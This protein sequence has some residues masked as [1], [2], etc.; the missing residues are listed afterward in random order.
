MKNETSKIWDNKAL[1]VLISII[2]AIL[3][4]VYVTTTEGDVREKTFEGV[5]VVLNGVDGLRD[6][7]NF[8]I[9]DVSANSVTVTLRGTLRNLSKLTANNIK[10]VVDV[11]KITSKGNNTMPFTMEYPVGIDKGSLDLVSSLPET[12]S[13]YVDKASSKSVEL[14]GDFSKGSVSEGFVAGTV[15]FDPREVTISG[16]ENEIN[17]VSYAFVEITRENVDKTLKFDSEYTLVDAEGKEVELGNIRL[18]PQTVSVTL[19]ITAT[20]E[21][22]LSV[23]IVDGGGATMENVKLKFE[24]E[25][26]TIAGDAA[27]LEGI[28]KISLG[29][30]DLSSFVSTF[31]EKFPIVLD[32]EVSN[33]TGLTEAK[34]TVEVLGLKTAMFNVTN[35]SI[36]NTPAGRI[37]SPVTEMVEVMLRGSQDAIDK[38]KANNIRAVIDLAEIGSNPGVF[39]VNAKIYVDGYTG[40]GAVSVDEDDY[41]LYVKII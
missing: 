28:N 18:E 15:S 22:P 38:V 17:R 9:S 16:P 1:M 37:S 21:V 39:Q 31:E 13:F 14:K 3:V 40:V 12:L 33:V 2:S 8:V 32:N 25:T 27:T 19:P 4:W 23:D 29:T 5:Q 20:K 36:I 35:I 26:I 41:K 34:V 11:S 7:E 10:A 30:I 24:P 6:R